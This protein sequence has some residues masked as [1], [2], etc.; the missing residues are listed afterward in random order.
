MKY[1]FWPIY[2]THHQLHCVEF[3]LLRVPLSFAFGH[4]Y[5]HSFPLRSKAPKG[6]K[7][8]YLY[9][10]KSL[11]VRICL[12]KQAHYRARGGE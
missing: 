1:F 12:R 7:H 3:E 4:L 11:F 6:T 2:L 10:S 5:D 9:R 8:K